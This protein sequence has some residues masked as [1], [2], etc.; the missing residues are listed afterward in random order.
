MFISGRNTLLN[1]TL[2]ILAQSFCML[3]YIFVSFLSTSNYHTL[4]LS[5][6]CAEWSQCNNK[7]PSIPLRI[8]RL[9]MSDHKARK[10]HHIPY[11]T[12]SMRHHISDHTTRNRTS[13]P[14]S[15]T[16]NVRNIY[17]FIGYQRSFYLNIPFPFNFKSFANQTYFKNLGI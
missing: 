17:H 7:S 10:W 2:Y 15:H 9:P 3:Y 4:L 13:Y 8:S 12:A 11:Y 16:T 5:C 14:R 6:D 1:N